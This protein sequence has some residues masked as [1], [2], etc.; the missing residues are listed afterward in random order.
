MMEPDV[1]PARRRLV[2][3]ALLVAIVAV[4]VVF[5]PTVLR[6]VDLFGVEQVEVIGSRFIEPYAVVRAAGIGPS[7]NL[8]DDGAVWSAGVRTLPLVA[9]VRIT[10]RF[11]PSTVVIE[12]RE[13]EPVALVAGAELLPVDSTG[14]V[15]AIEPAGAILDLP[16][17]V[18]VAVDEDALAGGSGEP[19]LMLLLLM[20]AHEPALAGRVS[21]VQVVRDGLRVLFRDDGPEALFPFESSTAHLTHLRLAYMDLRS[22]AELKRARRIDVRFRD[23][24]VVSFL[25]SP[26]S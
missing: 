2:R 10:R 24:V 8:F 17:L 3:G 12:V 23:Q 20:N 25:H 13:V 21:Q 7:S 9:G 26:V 5:A 4:A 22:R 19:A 14:R 16:I 11:F 18:G 6:E 15:L 1:R